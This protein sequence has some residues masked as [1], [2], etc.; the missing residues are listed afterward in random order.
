MPLPSAVA[1]ELAAPL[2]VTVAP[3]PV[4][5]KAPEMMAVTE[6]VR[7]PVTPP[8]TAEIELC[9]MPAP[10]ASPLVLTVAAA[11]LEELQVALLVR[12]CVLPSLKVPVAVSC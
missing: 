11:G 7:E 8:W 2:K 6:S 12:F 1:V 9:P 10:V 5:V 4:L 3:A